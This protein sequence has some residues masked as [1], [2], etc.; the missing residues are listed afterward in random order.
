MMSK[1]FQPRQ[2]FTGDGE[3]NPFNEDALMWVYRSTTN[4]RYEVGYFAPSGEWFAD[5]SYDTKELAGA[6][7]RYLNGGN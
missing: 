6:R 4:N 2:W 3:P 5:S 1:C 7:V